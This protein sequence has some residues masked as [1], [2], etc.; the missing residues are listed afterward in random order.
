MHSGIVDKI[1]NME[2]METGNKIEIYQDMKTD[3]TVR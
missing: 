1:D 2:E 3:N